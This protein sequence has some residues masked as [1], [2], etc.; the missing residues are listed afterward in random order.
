MK[1]LI[2]CL[3]L[4]LLF[5]AP[6]VMAEP[7][8]AFRS[9][10]YPVPRFLSLR[11]DEVYVRSGP[12]RK[13]PVQWVFK[14]AGLPVEVIL[15]YDNWRKI[16]DFDGSVGWVHQSLLSGKRTAIIDTKQLV[17]IYKKPNEKSRVMAKL[18]SKLVVE[19][20]AC[21]TLWCSVNAT[22]YKGWIEKKMLWGVYEHEKFD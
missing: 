6:L 16:R 12:G 15:E 17:E 18:E 13:Y 10:N 7:S 4:L 5:P 2:I 3:S 1:H 21:E 8:E 11:S 14:K 19:I 22:G 20:D 9:T